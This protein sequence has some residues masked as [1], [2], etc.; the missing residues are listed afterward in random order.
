[1]PQRVIGVSGNQRE[2]NLFVSDDDQSS[3]VLFVL[4][5]R[6]A[7]ALGGETPY[8]GEPQ[9]ATLTPEYVEKE[10]RRYVRAGYGVALIV[11]GAL[12]VVLLLIAGFAWAAWHAIGGLIGST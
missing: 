8:A 12:L 11:L 1:V 9:P 4:L 7:K 3:P 6:A 2:R 10:Y 5:V